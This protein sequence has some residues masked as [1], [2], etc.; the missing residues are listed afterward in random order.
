MKKSFSLLALLFCLTIVSVSAQKTGKITVNPKFVGIVE[1]YDHTCKTQIYVD[2]TLAG[3]SP[4]ALESKAASFSV[5]VPRGTH[6]IYVINLAF[7]EGNWEEH[8]KENNYSIDA[9][10]KGTVTLKKKMSINLTFDI[11]K[12]DAEV[13][14]KK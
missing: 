10:Y 3:E 8:T 5:Q 7:Y 11:D 12:E 14:I 6:E 2:G 1:G 9:S 13:K 4:E